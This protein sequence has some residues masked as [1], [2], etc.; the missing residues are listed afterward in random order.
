MTINIEK[1]TDLL[2]DYN[3][4][5]LF[6]KVVNA[7]A[8]YVDCP[9]EIMVNILLTDDA[10]IR[11]INNDTRNID[12]S[13]DVLSFPMLDYETPGNFDFI[14]EEDPTLFDYETGEL[15][16]GDIVI[17]VETALRQA[18]EFNHSYV[19]ELAFLCAHSMLHLSG[20]DHMEDDE[21]LVMEKM[22]EEILEGINI[23]RDYE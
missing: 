23:T 16:L 19:R 9:Y 8:D 3:F 1:E 20:F 22:Q 10:N 2:A 6:D 15:M 21:R 4:E 5:E 18:K 12:K 11:E 7:A 17:S 14:D 13:T